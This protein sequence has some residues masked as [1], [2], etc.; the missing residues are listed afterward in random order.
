MISKF[1]FMKNYCFIFSIQL[2]ILFPAFSQSTI[3]VNQLGYLTNQHKYAWINDVRADT[4]FWHLR[5]SSDS[6]I[7]YSAKTASS[8]KLDPATG[9]MVTRLDFRSFNKPGTYFIEVEKAGRSFSFP[10]SD[11]VYNKVW[12]AGIKSYYFQR[13]GMDLGVKYAGIWAR[14]ASHTKDALFYSGYSNGKIIEGEHHLSIGGWYDAGD[15]GKKIV[16]ASLALFAFLKLAEM[17]P[18]KIK[19]AKIDIPNPW[20]GLPDMLAEAK[21]ELDWFFTMQESSG[22]VHHLIVSPD[23]FIGPPQ[24]DTFPRYITGVSS[25]AT[26]D[27]AASMAM[28]AKVFRIYLPSYADSCLNA[29]EKAW[30]YLENNPA[31]FPSG[32]YHDPEGIHAT[33]A[34]EDPNDKDERLWASAELYHVTGKKI[35]MEYFEKNC[36]H[37]SVSDYGWWFDPHNYAFYTWLLSP[38]PGKNQALV[39]DLKIKIRKHAEAI[40]ALSSSNAYGVALKPDQYIW[41]SN[42]YSLNIGMELLIINEIFKTDKYTDAAL[43]QLNYILG[44]NSLNLSFVSN[45][46]SNSVKDPHQSI[47]SYDTI[48]LSPPGFIPGGPN[49][50]PQDPFLVALVSAHH[51]SPAKCYVDNHWSYASNE[52]CTCYNSG[53]IMLAGF[54][55]KPESNTAIKSVH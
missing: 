50:F 17:H 55:F 45:F 21:W 36:S 28:A 30:R 38:G 5:N 33:G 41:G 48:S 32:G 16:P 24:N 49:R 26:S 42:S 44:C 3:K 22:A 13:S 53:L 10:V 4:I 14:K 52:V 34:Y 6:S 54:F 27:F 47:N 7:L 8:H 2:F 31:I 1:H 37:F 25:A 20:K 35:Y 12:K 29:A 40:S 11:N 15:F 18:E 23:F 51:P 19:N 43:Q 9:E 39:E 46:G